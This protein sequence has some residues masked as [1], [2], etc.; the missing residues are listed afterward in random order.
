MNLLFPPAPHPPTPVCTE[1]TFWRELCMV[2]FVLAI[3]SLITALS[4][5][6]ARWG[7]SKGARFWGNNVREGKI[8]IIR[9]DRNWWDRSP[10]EAG[11]KGI[12]FSQSVSPTL[13]DPMACSP[14]GS[15]VHGILQA[16]NTG[17]GCHFLLQEGRRSMAEVKRETP[18]PGFLLPLDWREAPG[19]CHSLQAGDTRRKLA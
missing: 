10:R 11:G 5:S 1:L 3:H 12:V 4:G 2:S 7:S 18:K 17:V 16:R 6:S 19:K 9:E 8:W 14:P 13:C 15:S